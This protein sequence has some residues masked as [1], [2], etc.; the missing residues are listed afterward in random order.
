MY[1]ILCDRKFFVLRVFFIRRN[2]IDFVY[3]KINYF[4]FFLGNFFVFF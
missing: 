1:V 3:S 2:D 4:V